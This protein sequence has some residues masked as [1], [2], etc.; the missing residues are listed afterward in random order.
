MTT[1]ALPL[2]ASVT[3]E[4]VRELNLVSLWLVLGVVKLI[5]GAPKLT[6]AG[7]ALA[8]LR[9]LE[10]RLGDARIEPA[11]RDGELDG[12]PFAGFRRVRV[13]QLE[14]HYPATDG[15]GFTLGPLDVE[16][17][18][19]ELVFITGRNGS[20]KSTFA[21][22]LAGLYRPSAGRIVVDGVPLADE[23]RN[24]WRMLISTVF[25]EHCIFERTHG[26][27]AGAEARAP[28]LLARFQLAHKTSIADGR[29]SNRALS[30]GQRKR[31]AMV[32]AQLSDKP[33]LLLDEWAA[34]QDPEFRETFYDS[35][36]PQLRDEGRLVIVITHDETYF[37]RADRCLR[38]EGDRFVEVSP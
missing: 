31:L 34:E 15:G 37:S 23:T 14:F 17:E 35:L 33:V 27:D 13:E 2:V 20:G 1:F 29:V 21:R 26:L 11:V 12:G 28:E 5:S 8:R 22:L 10:E 30:T 32:L 9:D 19:G 24:A 7:A 16:F 36:L 4:E 6:S 25:V 38:L 3:A 18:R